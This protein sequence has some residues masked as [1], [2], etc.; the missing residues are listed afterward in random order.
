MLTLLLNFFKLY[1]ITIPKA[2]L[3]VSYRSFFVLDNRLGVRLNAHLLFTPFFGDRSLVGRF[4]GLIIRIFFIVFGI[5]ILLALEIF[6]LFLAPLYFLFFCYLFFKFSMGF[7]ALIAFLVLIYLRK[8]LFNPPLYLFEYKDGDTIKKFVHP[9]SKKFLEYILSKNIFKNPERLLKEKDI[10]F[11]TQKF[12]LDLKILVSFLITQANINISRSGFLDRAV[13]IGLETNASYIGHEVMLATFLEILPDWSNFLVKQNKEENWL[14]ETLKFVYWAKKKNKP[15][16]IWDKDY[17]VPFMGGVN[18]GLTGRVTPILNQYSQDITSLSTKGLLNEVV[19]REDVLRRCIEILSRPK[20]NC[21]LLV[22]EPGSG[23]TSFVGGIA[24]LIVRGTDKKSLRFKRVVSVNSGAFLGSGKDASKISERLTAVLDE[25]ELSGGIIPF[26]DEIHNI[27]ASGEGDPTKSS[28]FAILEQKLSS[29]KFQFIATTTSKNYAKYIEQNESFSKV[30]EKVELL[31]TTNEETL[32]ILKLNSTDIE[33]SLGIIISYPAISLCVS[34]SADIIYSKVFPDKA[35]NILNTAVE[36]AKRDNAKVVGRSHVELSVQM[37][38]KVPIL[39]LKNLDKEK[40]LNL[41]KDIHKYLVDQ[42]EAVLKV[43][44]AVRRGV[45]GT[46]DKGKPISTLLFLGP[47]GVG[48]TETAKA[49]ARSFY[50]GEDSLIRY[51]LNQFQDKLASEKLIDLMTNKVKSNPFCLLLLDEFE[52]APSELSLIFLQLLDEGFMQNS[53]GETVKFNNTI[54]I[55]TS[56]VGSQEIFSSLKLGSPYL[57]ISKKALIAAQKT[58]AP[59]LLNRFNS[60]V[61]FKTLSAEDVSKIAEIKINLLKE[62]V[63]ENGVIVKFTKNFIYQLSKS[64]FSREYG[65]R[66]M[67]RFIQDNVESKLAKD[68]VSGRLK[69]GSSITLDEKYLN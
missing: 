42:E 14:K 57:E 25:V 51:N 22:G 44:D 38:S 63:K 56:N 7:F 10:L 23:K 6:L 46:R 31:P 5:Y 33:K 59:E 41:E 34:L 29:G 13:R 53:L 19:G 32:E 36:I 49:L 69:R 21:V 52:K 16:F 68:L 60:V 43:S 27:S 4:T 66:E 55:A 39:N 61:V 24:N 47:T 54:I 9:K 26:I 37:V 3:L 2:I 1:L 45:T 35:V 58:F 30:F 8:I 20:K 15:I 65:A 48:K 67:E 28:V 40:L 17:S 64:A 18:R 11:L 12:D 50:G 62:R